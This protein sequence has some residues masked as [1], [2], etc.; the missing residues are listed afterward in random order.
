MVSLWSEVA[1]PPVVS[2]TTCWSHR[3]LLD[4]GVWRVEEG[5]GGRGR[6]MSQGCR[7]LLDTLRALSSIVHQETCI[8]VLRKLVGSF[9]GKLEGDLVFQCGFLVGRV[10]PFYP[11]IPLATSLQSIGSSLWLLN[12]GCFNTWSWVH[13]LVT[14]NSSQLREP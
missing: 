13:E 7:L 11:V 8:C 1:Q 5:G 2:W 10:F 6:E 4:W 12:H 14:S 3:K 9:I